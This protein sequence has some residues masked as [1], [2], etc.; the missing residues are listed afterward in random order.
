MKSKDYKTILDEMI[1]E[2]NIYIFTNG[3][4][5][6]RYTD[7]RLMY[8]Y[9][10]QINQNVEIYQME[11]EEAINFCKEKKECVSFVIGS[12]Y[13]YGDVKKIVQC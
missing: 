1:E 13:I 12:F 8:D 9:A 3:N 5:K 6:K 7:N 4:D 10:K 11:L 2:E